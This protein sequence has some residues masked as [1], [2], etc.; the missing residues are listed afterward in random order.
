M[1]SFGE[2]LSNLRKSKGLNQK[3]LADLLGY[4]QPASVSGIE[5]GKTPIDIIA[6]VKI[7]DALQVDLHWLITGQNYDPQKRLVARFKDTYSQL[8]QEHDAA[9]EIVKQLESRP[10]PLTAEE[11][12]QLIHNRGIVRSRTRQMENF[13]NQ[14][15]DEN[16]P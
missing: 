15:Q 11:Q 13:I 8:Q 7:A 4:K 2:R 12:Q 14:F 9:L 1:P 6:L 10:D 3:Q 5:A 16:A